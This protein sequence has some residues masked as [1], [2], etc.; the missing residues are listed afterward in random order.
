MKKHKKFIVGLVAGYALAFVLPPGKIS[1][2]LG[3]QG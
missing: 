1:G 2:K 3:K